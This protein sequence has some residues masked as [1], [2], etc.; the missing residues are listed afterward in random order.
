MIGTRLVP[1]VVLVLVLVPLLGGG[2]PDPSVMRAAAALVLE[3]ANAADQALTGLERALAPGLDAARRGAAQV[4][5]GE[6]DPGPEL[7][8]AAVEVAAAD[9]AAVAARE[10]VRTLEGARLAYGQGDPVQLEVPAGEVST[11]A[12][13]LESTA[14]AADA[15]AG[16]RRR[17]EGLVGRLEDVLV[18]LDG[19]SLDEARAELAAVRADHDALAA[20]PV[21][22]ATLPVWLDTTDAMI[23]VMEAIVDA[24]AAGD[25]DAALDAAG[26]FAALAE[27]AA[28]ADRALRIAIGEGGSAV[29][30]APL[31]R[32]A[33][34]LRAV[35][36]TRAQVASI[37]QTVGR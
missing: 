4:V 37:V 25:E 24:T 14:P 13:Q 19:G 23:G 30:A 33:D 1:A 15:F 32:L 16:M 8:A 35:A 22:L 18:A 3:R 36:Q 28:P 27:E 2:G 34:L 12:A 10:A 9:A 5:T 29:T 20:W 21:E 26:E 31:G 17:A 11:L 7:R 6:E